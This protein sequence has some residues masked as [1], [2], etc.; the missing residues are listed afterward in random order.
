MSDEEE[1]IFSDEDEPIVVQPKK[2]AMT[3]FASVS[4]FSIANKAKIESASPPTISKSEDYSE[5]PQSSH[6]QSVSLSSK[7]FTAVVQDQ[8]KDT[9]TR[10]KT[11]PITAIAPPVE[12][13]NIIEFWDNYFKLLETEFKI[14]TNQ[15]IPTQLKSLSQT[16]KDKLASS[17]DARVRPFNSLR[18]KTFT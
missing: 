17:K 3:R 16:F 7:N 14:A 15:E 9:I 12:S 1:F 11:E 5:K 4:K 6:Q 18:S 13:D 2:P 10:S 8:R